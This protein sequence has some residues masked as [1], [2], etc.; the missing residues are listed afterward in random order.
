MD[1][2]IIIAYNSH[3]KLKVCGEGFSC[4]VYSSMSILLLVYLA[5][6]S[7]DVEVFDSCIQQER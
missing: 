3:E 5:V 2:G 1:T 6:V 7:M 4:S